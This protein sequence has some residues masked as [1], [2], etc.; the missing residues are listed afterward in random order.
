MT[1][2]VKVPDAQVL[3]PPAVARLIDLALDEDLGRGDVTSEAIFGSHETA[4]AVILA[5]SE[6]VLSG[7]DVAMAVFQAV[8]RRILTTAL[9]ADG[10]SIHPQT[11][12]LRVEGPLR[13]ILA[14]ERTALNFLQRLSGIATLSRRYVQAVAGTSA[15]IVDTR[16][17]L[18]GFRFLDK[19]A[20]RHGGAHNHRADLGSGV[21]IKDNHVAAAGDVAEAIRRA[22]EYAPHSVRIEAEVTSIE[23]V[24]KAL[25]ARADIILLDNMSPEMVREAMA[26]LPNVGDPRRPLIEVSGGVSLATVRAYAEAGADLISVGA[27]THSVTAADLSLEVEV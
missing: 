26:T 16:K 23:Q 22:R 7:L 3:L 20:V 19:R 5:K 9:F 10:S 12:V 8:D 6:L 21:L 2:T 11:Q 4:Q 14:A 18:P 25:A 1:P 27:L 17:T 15:R 13:S 24:S